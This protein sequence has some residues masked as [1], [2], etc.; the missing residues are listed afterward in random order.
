MRGLTHAWHGVKAMAVASL[1]VRGY[2][3][4]ARH[5][6]EA[7]EYA[8]QSP[9]APGEESQAPSSKFFSLLS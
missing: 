8:L 2:G 1:V 3:L 4:D 5:H 6:S 9:H 7:R